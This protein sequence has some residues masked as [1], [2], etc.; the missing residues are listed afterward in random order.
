[1]ISRIDFGH[2]AMNI[3]GGSAEQMTVGTTVFPGR[4]DGCPV[5]V[6]YHGDI[7]DTA[8]FWP[9]LLNRLYQIVWT[10]SGIKKV[11]VAVPYNF[12]PSPFDGAEFEGIEIEFW[13]VYPEAIRLF[14]Y[15]ADRNR[16]LAAQKDAAESEKKMG[17]ALYREKA[18]GDIPQAQG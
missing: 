4:K 18:I 5:D 12:I 9:T 3:H 7:K 10:G 15:G 2:L 6:M 13:K 1:M 14:D 8:D 16:I 11:Y 17:S